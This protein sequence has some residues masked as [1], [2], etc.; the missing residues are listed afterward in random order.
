[1][2]IAFF[3]RMDLSKNLSPDPTDLIDWINAEGLLDLD[4]DFPEDGDLYQAGLD[5][6]GLVNLAAAVEDEYRIELQPEE[7]IAAKINTP[8]KLAKLIAAKLA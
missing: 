1:V 6:T 2:S 5:S 3:A 8:K 4:W 7:L